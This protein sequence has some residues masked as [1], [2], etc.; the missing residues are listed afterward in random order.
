[1]DLKLNIGLAEL[2]QLI[3]QLP[4]PQRDRLQAWMAEDE[5]TRRKQLEE[6]LLRAPTF[7]EAQVER[8]AKIREA[9]DQWR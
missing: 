9:I 2:M 1:M 3:M 4:K 6:L 5:K 7:T 8:M